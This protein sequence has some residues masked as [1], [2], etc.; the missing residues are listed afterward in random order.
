V[1]DCRPRYHSAATAIA[2]RFAEAF[3]PPC[4]EGP[5]AE[6]PCHEVK[7]ITTTSIHFRM[8]LTHSIS[9][10]RFAAGLSG[11]FTFTQSRDRPDLYGAS[12]L[13]LTIPSNPMA[14][15]CRYVAAPSSSKY[16]GRQIPWPLA[17]GGSKVANALAAALPWV[18]A[19]AIPLCSVHDIV[20]SGRILR[21]IH[22]D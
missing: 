20:T 5:L 1:S 16:S 6:I 7:Q 11:V 4:R 22:D 8:I 10:I 17:F 18:S 13:L 21:L 14:H 12:H 15:A 9:A 19:Q 3:A 2:S